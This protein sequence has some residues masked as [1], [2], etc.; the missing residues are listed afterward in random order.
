MKRFLQT[1]FRKHLSLLQELNYIDE[2]GAPTHDGRWAA[3][4]RLDHP[5]LIAQLIREREFSELNPKQ[6]AALM[7]PFVMD[8]DKEIVISREL[9]QRTNPLW[10]RFRNMLQ[11][12]KPFAE[13]LI[14]RGFDVPNIMFW[15]AAAVFLWA[16][17]VEWGELIENVDADEGDLAML[18]LRTADHLR[19][20]LSLEKE[21]PKLAATAAK[22]LN[23]LMRAPLV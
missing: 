17:E 15:P 8:K 3:R 18:I 1:N 7:A 20:L 10:K 6:L 13:L 2:Q 21:E 16:E 14:A 9:W 23:S 5:L 11:K 22:A 12:L 19:Q 4:L